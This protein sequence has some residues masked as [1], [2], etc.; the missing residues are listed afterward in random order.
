[1]KFL[2]SIACLIT[3]AVTADAA[4]QRRTVATLVTQIDAIQN[5]TLVLISAL[6]NFT[7]TIGTAVPIQFANNNI[8]TAVTAATNDAKTTAPYALIDGIA[9]L[10]AVQNLTT[11]IFESLNVLVEK[12]SLFAAAG[13]T[14]LV[15]HNLDVQHAASNEFSNALYDISPSAGL[16]LAYNA[17]SCIDNA[18]SS[19]RQWSTVGSTCAAATTTPTTTSS[20]APF[21]TQFGAAPSDVV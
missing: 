8:A 15:T 1:M 3:L 9:I 11:T 2:R 20:P 6:N 4:L 18:F 12:R 10:S 5:D 14:D 16:G 13:L 21:A 7:G 17:A 19:A